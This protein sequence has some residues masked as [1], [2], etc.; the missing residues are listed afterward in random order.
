V[1]GWNQPANSV[2][3][4]AAA[5]A[6]AAD[7]AIALFCVTLALLND[8]CVSTKPGEWHSFTNGLLQTLLLLLLLLLPAV[9]L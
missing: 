4:A 1:V 2:V 9:C 8:V 3:A 6:A 5:A 7:I